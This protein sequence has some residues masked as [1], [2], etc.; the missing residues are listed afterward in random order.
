MNW[1]L[2][3]LLLGLVFFLAV[4]LVKPIGVSTQFVILD[5][6]IWSSIDN[7]LISKKEDGKYTSSNAYLAKSKGKYARSVANPLNYGFV[8]VIAMLVGG[9][10]SGLTRKTPVEDKYVPEIWQANF[11]S[12]IV[13]RCLSVFV[14]GFIVL[15]GVRLAGGCTSGHMMSGMMQTS[16]SGYLFSLGVFM[17]AIPT[18]IILYRK[19]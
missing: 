19:G 3:G 7:N 14:S 1:K 9:A 12:S 13:F 18:A 6:I 5:G 8:F 16:L 11:G 10:I 4:F 2:A 17:V 15:Y